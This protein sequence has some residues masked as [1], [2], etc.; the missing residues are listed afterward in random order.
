MKEII[1]I[2]VTKLRARTKYDFISRIK[3]DL[4]INCDI[5]DASWNNVP[6]DVA[7]DTNGPTAIHNL[8]QWP[9]ADPNAINLDWSDSTTAVTTSSLSNS[10]QVYENLSEVKQ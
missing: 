8:W 9:S 5:S 6:T 3:N 7:F 2:Y 4:Q 1:Y 10:N